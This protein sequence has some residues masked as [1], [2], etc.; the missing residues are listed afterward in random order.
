MPGRAPVAPAGPHTRWKAG[1]RPMGSWH[2]C[3]TREA[4]IRLWTATT[5]DDG[6]ALR[7]ILPEHIR[8]L[9]GRT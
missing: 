6:A 2:Y 1:W 7:A 4:L 3:Q 9:L 5:G 8:F